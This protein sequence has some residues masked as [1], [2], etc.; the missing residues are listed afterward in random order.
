MGLFER[1]RNTMGKHAK[2]KEKRGKRR[3]NMATMHHEDI[4]PAPDAAQGE[5]TPKGFDL[6]LAMFQSQDTDVLPSSGELLPNDDD[7]C[8][9]DT[10]VQAQGVNGSDS[11]SGA[12]LTPHRNHWRGA[13]A[14]AIDACVR[15]SLR[16]GSASERG[17]RPKND[18]S[19][20]RSTRS[21]FFAISDGIGGAPHGDVISRLACRAAVR[22]HE[23]GYDLEGAFQAA[24]DEVRVIAE[25]LG[26]GDGATLLLAERKGCVLDIL[27]VGDTHAYLLRDGELYLINNFGRVDPS[28]G[29]PANALDKSIG[30]YSEGTV[31]DSSQVSLYAGD[32]LLLCT[33]GVWSFLG[34]AGLKGALAP[35]D[36]GTDDVFDRA[37]QICQEAIEAYDGR[38]NATCFYLAVDDIEPAANDADILA[39][40]AELYAKGEGVVQDHGE[41]IRWWEWAA[42]RGD[43]EAQYELGQALHKGLGMPRNDQVA[44]TWYQRSAQN[45]HPLA[46]RALGSLFDRGQGTGRDPE[47]AI[48]WWRR[49]AQQGDP[50]SAYQLGR[51]FE[52][53]QDIAQACTWYRRSA[54]L[55]GL[56]VGDEEE[57]QIPGSPTIRRPNPAEDSPTPPGVDLLS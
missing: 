4:A 23:Q 51:H 55:G 18:D 47:Q 50:W 25:D 3:T 10:S 54:E 32:R 38:D 42:H 9:L 31:P 30:A 41:A 14:D 43:V 52:D 12:D 34:N 53:A 5:S 19:L 6:A 26:D 33:D 24:A 45:G 49:A 27:S 36:D 2:P 16:A 11:G 28:L 15:V 39:G 56:P 1:K 17:P 37:M 46:Q 44:F 13:T 29:R 8:Q 57:D 40:V 22:A 21:D 48:L 35:S 20:E 7:A